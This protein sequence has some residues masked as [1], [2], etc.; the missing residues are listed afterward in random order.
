M[1]WGESN[2]NPGEI[3]FVTPFI[4][5]VSSV[6]MFS[7]EGVCCAH[8]GT[9]RNKM[10][11]RQV[12]DQSHFKNKVDL[13][14]QGP[15]LFCIDAG[16]SSSTTLMMTP[17]L[18]VTESVNA[19]VQS[20][21]YKQYFKETWMDEVSACEG[22]ETLDKDELASIQTP[23]QRKQARLKEIELDEV[24]GGLSEQDCVGRFCASNK[25]LHPRGGFM[26]WYISM[27]IL[28]NNM[29]FSDCPM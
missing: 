24:T 1:V 4:R 20:L 13:K 18:R 12:N 29:T 3:T 26:K 22:A 16:L 17:K 25:T 19:I 28:H 10:C 9:S 21:M 6:Q 7:Q 15:T 23:L 5:G 14:L 11:F 8:I 2:S 27:T